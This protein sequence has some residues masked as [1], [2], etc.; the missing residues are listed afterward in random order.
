MWDLDCSQPGSAL[1]SG[2]TG[3][4]LNPTGAGFAVLKVPFSITAE[5]SPCVVQFRTS[6]GG[7]GQVEIAKLA[8]ALA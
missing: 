8:L 1:T 3:G 5:E 7:K 2:L 4:M 6:Y